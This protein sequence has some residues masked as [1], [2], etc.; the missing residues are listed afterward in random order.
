MTRTVKVYSFHENWEMADIVD[1]FL[2]E[3]AGALCRAFWNRWTLGLDFGPGN[4]GLW[5]DISVQKHTEFGPRYIT[6]DL[7]VSALKILDSRDKSTH[8]HSHT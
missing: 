7:C 2:K 1:S 4:A 8:Y 6:L 3:A 5:T